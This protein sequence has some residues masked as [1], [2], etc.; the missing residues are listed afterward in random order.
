MSLLNRIL[1]LE[2]QFVQEKTR[3]IMPSGEIVTLTGRGDFILQLAG[4][5]V[6]GVL[7]P[8]Q[9]RQARL[10]GA[11]T[12]IEEP[13]GGHMLELVRAWVNGPA[14]CRPDL[15]GAGADE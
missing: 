8:E 4:A 6:K 14:E 9:K 5:M 7:T 12:S 2:S 11:S 1:K 3:L 15:G 13:G 10:I